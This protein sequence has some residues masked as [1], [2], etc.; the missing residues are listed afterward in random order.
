[1]AERVWCLGFNRFSKAK[2][3]TFGFN[4]T[5][6]KSMKFLAILFLSAL[7]FLF[8][9]N[10]GYSNYN[11]PFIGMPKAYLLEEKAWNFFILPSEIGAGYGITNNLDF[12]LFTSKKELTPAIKYQFFNEGKDFF[13]LSSELNLGSE[14]SLDIIASKY[15]AMIGIHTGL[16]LS[17]EN[18]NEEFLLNNFAYHYLLGFDFPINQRVFG[19]L[20]FTREEGKKVKTNLYLDWYPHPEYG[21]SLEFQKTP[22]LSLSLLF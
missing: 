19:E 6:A 17:R 12:Y 11:H 7:L 13:T 4:K 9:P 21:I 15:I 22:R 8:I 16:G 14:E 20:S 1:M 18:D 10:Y 2:S 3:T 5:R